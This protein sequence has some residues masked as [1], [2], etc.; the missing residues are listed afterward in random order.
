MSSLLNYK[1][2]HILLIKFLNKYVWQLAALL[3][4]LARHLSTRRYSTESGGSGKPTR[5]RLEGQRAAIVFPEETKEV[6]TG[7]MLSDGSLK[8]DKRCVNSNA[9][10]QIEQKDRDFVELLLDLFH[11]IGIVGAKPRLV[12][13]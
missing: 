5:K 9:S 3:G 1:I 8:K 10:L 4:S 2:V 13:H 11:S 7:M 12:T 6:R